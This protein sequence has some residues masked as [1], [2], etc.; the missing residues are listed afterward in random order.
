MQRH[1]EL[2]A[3]FVP[4]AAARS[5]GGWLGLAHDALASSEPR[6]ASERPVLVKKAGGKSKFQAFLVE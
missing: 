2:P 3:G 4:A 6:G 1:A 5:A